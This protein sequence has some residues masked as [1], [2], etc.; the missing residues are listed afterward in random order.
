MLFLRT[1]KMWPNKF[2][3]VMLPS[4][5]Q[6]FARTGQRAVSPAGS[7]SKD[8]PVSFGKTPTQSAE[9]FARSAEDYKPETQS[10]DGQ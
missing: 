7:Y 6:I 10:E 3:F 9:E 2:V 8:D 1:D 5:K 4:K